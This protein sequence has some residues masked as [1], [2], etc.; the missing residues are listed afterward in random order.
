MRAYVHAHHLLQEQVSRGGHHVLL[1]AL[2][3]HVC[4]HAPTRPRVARVRGAA[5]G[6][7]R[8]AGA[9]GVRSV[10]ACGT[11]AFEGPLRGR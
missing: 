5:W 10:G 7:W 8:D 6:K 2:Y 1:N 11:G 3:V 4:A 9:C